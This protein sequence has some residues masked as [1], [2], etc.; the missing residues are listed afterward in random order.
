M[1]DLQFYQFKDY[2]GSFYYHDPINNKVQWEFPED[3]KVVNYETGLIVSAE[4]L[5]PNNK[6]VND[7]D[8]SNSTNS[9]SFVKVRQY[10]KT[11]RATHRKKVCL[12][13]LS[14]NNISVKELENAPYYPPSL[15]IERNHHF[16]IS[17]ISN[18]LNIK[19]SRYRSKPQDFDHHL[20]YE[21]NMQPNIVPL[22]KTSE[23][24]AKAAQE[25][26]KFILDYCKSGSKLTP[27]GLL[28]FV[29]NDPNII[30]ELYTQL[31]TVL[32]NNP[33]IDYRLKA[34]EL[35]CV[36]CSI[37]QIDPQS[38]NISIFGLI[39]SFIANSTRDPNRAIAKFA[40]ISYIRFISQKALHYTNEELDNWIHRTTLGFKSIGSCLYEQIWAQ[41]ASLPNCPIPIILHHLCQ[42][43]LSKKAEMSNGAL[44]SEGRAADV[45]ALINEINQSP[46][47]KEELDII[48]TA[49]IRD[50]MSVIKK[51]IMQLPMPVIPVNY[52]EQLCKC[53]DYI[54]FA[55]Q[56]PDVHKHTLMY[57]IGFLKDLAKLQDITNMAEGALA[58]KFGP[59]I[60]NPNPKDAQFAHVT[61]I[62]S[63]KFITQLLHD[64]DI[65][66]VYP[67]PE[68]AFAF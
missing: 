62:V 43:L 30:D 28:P 64:W 44:L 4:S 66:S 32:R 63:K 21:D 37:Y 12:S 13:T 36:V 48:K 5:S 29:T 31:I 9:I 26:F 11:I 8:G 7:I 50:L 25:M 47:Q 57:L 42:G 65:S 6:S 1:S 22:L 59:S 60:I 49:T 61:A 41:R 40:L 68:S 17:T 27:S 14:S 53:P 3:S 23:P 19:R 16:T 33:N 45:E 34:W 51:W 54:E 56:L 67:L 46:I 18:I 10:A 55:N 52:F 24:Y 38:P 35:L 2:K 20:S 15:L 39:S 58:L